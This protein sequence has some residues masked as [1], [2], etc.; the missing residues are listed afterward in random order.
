MLVCAIIG[1]GCTHCVQNLLVHTTAITAAAL[2]A[3]KHEVAAAAG[4]TIARGGE[5]GGNRT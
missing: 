5:R 2:A 4:W 3:A 1:Y